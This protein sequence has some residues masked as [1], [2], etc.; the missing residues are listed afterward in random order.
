MPVETTRSLETGV[1]LSNDAGK[2]HP[3]AIVAN[4]AR[5]AATEAARQWATG[6]PL[7]TP[8]RGAS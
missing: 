8:T 6:Y 1:R 4:R 5:A 7:A 3:A 2:A